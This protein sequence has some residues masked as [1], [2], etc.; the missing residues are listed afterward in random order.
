[1]PPLVGK[2]LLYPNLKWKTSLATLP[3]SHKHL[4]W[5]TTVVKSEFPSCAVY[6]LAW[7]YR[8]P[9]LLADMEKHHFE[10]RPA[11]PTI[12]PSTPG[13]VTHDPSL[14][15]GVRLPLTNGK[16]VPETLSIP[17]EDLYTNL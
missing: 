10:G 16:L 9:S 5:G 13:T 17:H 1:M 2:W 12:Y 15:L 8:L 11:S 7:H 14:Q 3:L 6:Q 4:E